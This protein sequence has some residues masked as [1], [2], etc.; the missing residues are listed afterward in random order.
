MLSSSISEVDRGEDMKVL[1]CRSLPEL[2]DELLLAP[3]QYIS[4][5]P[6]K[7]VRNATVDAL[8]IWVGVPERYLV[9]I[10][11]VI[12]L[13]YSSSL[14]LDD[15]QDS[16][17]L[18]RGRPSTHKIFGFAWTMNSADYLFVAALNEVR[19]L[20]NPE[21]LSVFIEELRCLYIGQSHD[22]YWT[23]NVLCPSEEDYLRMV[24]HKTGGLFRMIAKLMTT[25]STNDRTTTFADLITLVGR[26]FQI[27]DDYQNLVSPDVSPIS[28]HVRFSSVFKLRFYF[29]NK[30]T[31]QKGFCEDLEEGK[32]SLP[33]IHTLQNSNNK[34]QLLSI[35]Q[36]RRAA[37][38][39]S[40]ELKKVVLEHMS[41]TKSLEYTKAC[42]NTL[43]DEI[44]WEL[45]VVE[46]EFSAENYILKLLLEK[47]R[48]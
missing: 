5:L 21:S 48:V 10:K 37:G 2:N 40:F 12:D 16:S 22:L 11:S 42:L 25:V 17:S 6:S 29:L 34:I 7:G 47:L 20:N 1:I 39:L 4:S 23:R 19:K 31:Q 18:R 13:L 32:F 46:K 35:L 45:Q 27:R 30:Y 8:N 24:D 43:H 44:N 36:E 14:M 41:Q 38:G 3:F 28:V 15:M 26:Y 9:V 33:L